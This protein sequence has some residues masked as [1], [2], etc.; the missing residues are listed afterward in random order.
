MGL[1]IIWLPVLLL[2]AAFRYFRET[3]FRIGAAAAAGLAGLV[4]ATSGLFALLIGDIKIYSILLSAGGLLGTVTARLLDAYLRLAGSMIILGLILIISLMIL[5]KYSP[6]ISLFRKIDGYLKAK[7]QAD[8][9]SNDASLKKS[10]PISSDTTTEKRQGAVGGG[11]ICLLFGTALMIWTLSSFII[12]LPLFFASFVLGIVSIAQR[13]ILHGI[14]I[15]LLS[16]ILP[17]MVGIGYYANDNY[18]VYKSSKE[19]SNYTKPFPY[20]ENQPIKA[21][22]PPVESTI[23]IPEV[24]PP[25]EETSKPE[26]P[27]DFYGYNI[28]EYCKKV[29]DIMGGSYV[30]ENSCRRHEHETQNKLNSMQVPLEIRNYCKQ[31]GE[32]MGGSYVIAESCVRHEIEAKNKLQ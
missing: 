24:P 19:S 15:L 3:Q 25:V 16:V 30:I 4:F 18:Q 32:I 1:G 14:A 20:A 22:P 13:R 23:E 10:T 28:N 12:Y 11:W 31:T 2:V 17:I 27:D 21:I 9:L 26:V 7:Q 5:I 29:S 8:Q 6:I